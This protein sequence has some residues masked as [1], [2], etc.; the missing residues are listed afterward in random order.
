MGSKVAVVC[1]LQLTASVDVRI[2]PASPVA[3]N[4]PPAKMTDLKVFACGRELRHSH[5]SSGADDERF[6][7]T[8]NK[9]QTNANRADFN[10][11]GMPE[12]VI[13]SRPFLRVR[14][15]C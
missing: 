8:H 11:L 2:V 6:A 9:N 1:L 5:W 7:A 14:P 13:L 4:L 10:L 3:T 15:A 12:N